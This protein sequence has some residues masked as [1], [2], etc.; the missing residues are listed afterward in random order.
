MVGRNAVVAFFAEKLRTAYGTLR[1]RL[2]REIASFH[3]TPPPPLHVV[4]MISS[5]RCAEYL[6]LLGI[7]FRQDIKNPYKIPLMRIAQKAVFRNLGTSETDGS[8]AD[9]SF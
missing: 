4:G 3:F 2:N 6:R 5:C 8:N 1:S 9:Q 7:N